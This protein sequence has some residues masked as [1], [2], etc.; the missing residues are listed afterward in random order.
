MATIVVETNNQRVP[1]INVLALFPNQKWKYLQTDQHGEAT[2]TLHNETLPMTV[3]AET[4]REG[5]LSIVYIVSAAPR[6]SCLIKVLADLENGGR[7]VFLLTC[8]S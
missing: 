6:V 3:F 1:E 7:H 5:N 2:P 8:R 4:W